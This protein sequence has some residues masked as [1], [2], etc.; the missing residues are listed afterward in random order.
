LGVSPSEC[1]A[2]EDSANGAL[3]ALAAGLTCVIVPNGTTQHLKFPNVNHRM[4]SMNELPFIE[5]LSELKM[6]LNKGNL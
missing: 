3:A 4:N 5:L 2:F 1:L 6:N